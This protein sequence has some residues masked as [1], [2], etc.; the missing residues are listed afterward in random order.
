MPRPLKVI[1]TIVALITLTFS[2]LYLY[3]KHRYI[4]AQSDYAKAAQLRVSAELAKERQEN[5]FNN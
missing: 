5:Q 2:G 1:I 3:G 4:K